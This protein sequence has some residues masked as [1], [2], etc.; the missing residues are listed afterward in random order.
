M[1]TRLLLLIVCCCHGLMV[2][3]Q[4][5]PQEIE[6]IIDGK[7]ATVGVAI[8]YD[9]SVYTVANDQA[10]PIMSVFK[11][12]VSMT[13]LHKMAAEGIALDSMVCI[14]PEQMRPDTY[15]P[16]RDA[17]PDQSIRLSYRDIIRYTIV[18]SDNNTCDW[19]IDFV[20]GI[21][22]CD[23][24]VNSLGIE[25]LSLTQ[26]E[27]DMH[28]DIMNSYRNWSTPLAVAQ[29]LKK[30][31]T[32]EVLMAEHRVFLEQALLDCSTGMDKL[33]A[34][35]PEGIR[36]AH[37]TGHSDRTPS[38]V[39][40]GDAD[41]GVVYLPQGDVCYLVVLIKDSAEPDSVNARMMA[42]IAALVYRYLQP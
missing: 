18:Q 31:Y 12:H 4:H 27:H 28:V 5:L 41:A 42:D 26:T 32:E 19:L 33:R 29:L 1:K 9:D 37:K 11:L 24:Y 3:G 6:R 14:P 40:I 16:L 10:Y 23:A 38:G 7:Q 8:L 39:Q 36:L 30:L 17:Y 21:Q 20:G 25:G 2:S 22:R 13:A 34:G 35:L 15:S